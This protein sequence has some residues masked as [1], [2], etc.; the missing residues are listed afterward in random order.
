MIR[1]AQPHFILSFSPQPRTTDPSA[2]RLL[3]DVAFVRKQLR[4][5]QLLDAARAL[6][7]GT[8]NKLMLR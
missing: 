6:K 3:L 8:N 1:R 5:F 2:Q 7:Q 4:G